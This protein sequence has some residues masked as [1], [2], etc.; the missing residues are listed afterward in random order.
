MKYCL[1][2]NDIDKTTTP[3][4]AGLGW[5]TK[6]YK[7]DF[8]GKDVLVKQKQEG[9]K[10]RLVG[11]EMSGHSIPRHHYKIFKDNKEIGYVTSGTFSPSI[12]K[13]IGLGYIK[14]PFS[15][16]GTEIEIDSRGRMERAIVVKMPF[17]KNATHK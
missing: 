16:V 7:E 12:N 8:I 2:G 13:S 1:Y 11:F 5:I 15:K 3:L 10:R 14:T 17:Y 4:E 9:I 6:L